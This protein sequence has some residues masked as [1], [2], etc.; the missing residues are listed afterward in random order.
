MSSFGTRAA[1]AA[2]HGALGRLAAGRLELH[3]EFS[4]TTWAFGPR[5][6]RLAARVEVHSP[7]LYPRLVRARSV[8]LGEAYADGLW[9]C[10]DLVAL[11]RI[12]ALRDGAARSASPPTRPGLAPVSSPR[13]AAA[14]Q[15]PPRRS[16]QHRRPLRPRKRAL[17][18]LP[19]RRDDDVLE[20]LLRARGPGARGRSAQQARAHL[21]SGS[22]SAP[23]TTSSRSGP[24]GAGSRSTRPRTTAAG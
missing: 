13:D 6:A 3:E 17:R 16:R 15:H 4:A 7:A 11:F 8:G 10:D 1:R 12:G 20:R 9:D 2:V 23:A 5:D 19:R 18:E 14:A 21:P 24:G 22:I